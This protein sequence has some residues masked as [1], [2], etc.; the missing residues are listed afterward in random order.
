MR[1]TPVREK[2]WDITVIKP[3]ERHEGPH[4]PNK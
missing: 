1:E 2:F 3:S 4:R